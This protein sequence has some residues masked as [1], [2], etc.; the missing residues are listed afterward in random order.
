MVRTHVEWVN[1]LF[2]V[3]S[4]YIPCSLS[5]TIHIVKEILS[6]LKY[7]IFTLS[8]HGARIVRLL[9][10]CSSHFI[11][12]SYCTQ[13]H[14]H[15]GQLFRF[16]LF[17]WQISLAH[18]VMRLDFLHRSDNVWLF[19]KQQTYDCFELRKPAAATAAVEQYTCKMEKRIYRCRW[20]R[21]SCMT[22]YVCVL[23]VSMLASSIKPTAVCFC[24]SAFNSAM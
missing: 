12:T 22:V 16:C 24:V 10:T 4:A 19:D 13:T 20:Y 8:A 14:K 17:A 3:L 2:F 11:H 1:R 5:L 15:T 7:G 23:Y 9:N 6:G 18:A 21:C